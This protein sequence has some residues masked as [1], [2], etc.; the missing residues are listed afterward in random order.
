MSK[1]SKSEIKTTETKKLIINPG[2]GTTLSE[3]FPKFI[4]P[5]PPKPK[6]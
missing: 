3:S 1:K 6:K 5:K 2:D 4:A